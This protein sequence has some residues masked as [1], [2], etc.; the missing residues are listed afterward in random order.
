MNTL[1]QMRRTKKKNEENKPV[2]ESVIQ[3]QSLAPAEENAEKEDKKKKKEAKKTE[4][5]L[6]K[7]AGKL[8][9]AG[10][11]PPKPPGS[12][13]AEPAAKKRKVGRPRNEPPTA[14]SSSK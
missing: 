7:E 12:T 1:A 13:V 9:G 3:P 4:T 14:N 11:Y 8:R 5:Y 2:S 6:L 10:R